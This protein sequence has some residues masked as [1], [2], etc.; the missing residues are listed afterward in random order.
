MRQLAAP[1]RALIAGLPTVTSGNTL[2]LDDGTKVRLE[3][4]RPDKAAKRAMKEIIGDY[5]IVCSGTVKN[6]ELLGNCDVNDG[7]DLKAEMAKRGFAVH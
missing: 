7:K 5:D 3:G 4:I 6:G 2:K 1:Q